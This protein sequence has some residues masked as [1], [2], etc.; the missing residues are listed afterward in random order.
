MVFLARKWL[1]GICYRQWCDVFVR[2]C[3]SGV[4]ETDPASVYVYRKWWC[5]QVR[6]SGI[7]DV[8]CFGRARGG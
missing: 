8:L 7:V 5:K 6:V 2:G 1:G 4:L 3:N